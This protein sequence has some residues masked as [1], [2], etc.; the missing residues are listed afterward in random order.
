MSLLKKK[1]LTL[2]LFKE[3]YPKGEVVRRAQHIEGK[4][5]LLM[6]M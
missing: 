5:V 6:F 2:I 4:I 1:I 3:E